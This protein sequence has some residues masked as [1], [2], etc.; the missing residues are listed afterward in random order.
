MSTK[1]VISKKDVRT[2]AKEKGIELSHKVNIAEPV[3]KSRSKTKEMLIRA[4][5][6]VEGNDSCFKT[7]VSNCSQSGCTW[8]TECQR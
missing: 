7:E 1:K 5:Q 4:I 6:N 2:M 8:F 3:M